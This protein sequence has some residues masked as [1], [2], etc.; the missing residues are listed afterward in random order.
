MCHNKSPL[1]FF[2]KAACS[3][4]WKIQVY[5]ATV[6]AQ[7]MYGLET[8]AL[9]AVQ[10]KKLDT[11]QQR[12]LRAILNIEPAWI[13]R[14]SNDAVMNTAVEALGK[15]IRLSSIQIRAKKVVFLGHILRTTQ[16]ERFEPMRMATFSNPDDDIFGNSVQLRKDKEELVDA[17]PNGRTRQCKMHGTS[18]TLSP[19]NH[20]T[21]PTYNFYTK[22][23]ST[24]NS[25]P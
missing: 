17:E 9:S 18:R 24:E 13:S 21:L 3:L 6:K 5:N 4:G 25:E 7:L 11:F 8:S 22:T 15:D 2:K 16:Y 12:G 19:S 14:I 10:L 23:P 1:P 20:S